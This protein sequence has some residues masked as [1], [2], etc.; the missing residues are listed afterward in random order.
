ML[1]E[2]K[3][4]AFCMLQLLPHRGLRHCTRGKRNDEKVQNQLSNTRLLIMPTLFQAI[5]KEMERRGYPNAYT[6]NNPDRPKQSWPC[7]YLVTTSV[8]C[9]HN[10]I[11]PNIYKPNDKNSMQRGQKKKGKT[12]NREKINKAARN[13][14]CP[15]LLRKLTVVRVGWQPARRAAQE[16]N[17]M[18]GPAPRWHLS[19]DA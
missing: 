17:Q 13:T 8:S 12:K 6:H 4:T 9:H 3:R 19:F 1:Y 7:F 15:A 14:Q 10:D 11:S 5:E 16:R 2:R 18:R